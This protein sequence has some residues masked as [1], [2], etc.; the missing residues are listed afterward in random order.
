MRACSGP[1]TQLPWGLHML[2]SPDYDCSG[3]DL[4]PEGWCRHVQ[5]CNPAQWRV[6]LSQSKLCLALQMTTWS[7]WTVNGGHTSHSSPTRP[8]VQPEGPR[9]GHGSHVRMRAW[10][11]PSDHLHRMADF[12]DALGGATPAP[13]MGRCCCC[14]DGLPPGQVKRKTVLRFLLIYFIQPV[15]QTWP[16]PSEQLLT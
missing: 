3:V 10:T 15:L 14:D 7:V 16:W 4:C 8:A 9:Q 6:G 1:Q 12:S 2:Y 5:G 11:P 13:H